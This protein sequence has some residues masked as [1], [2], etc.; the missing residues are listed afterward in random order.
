MDAA[1]DAAGFGKAVVVVPEDVFDQ[2]TAGAAAGFDFGLLGAPQDGVSNCKLNGGAAFAGFVGDATGEALE[3]LLQMI[4]DGLFVLAAAVESHSDIEIGFGALEFGMLGFDCAAEAFAAE[5]AG[6]GA[7]FVRESV[8][9]DDGLVVA[10]AIV[11]RD[12]LLV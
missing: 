12:Y 8:L 4:T 6:F 9:V 5:V 1:E 7:E 11:H 3:Q 10:V 2:A